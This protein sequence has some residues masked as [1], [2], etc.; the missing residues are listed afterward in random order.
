MSIF[1][2]KMNAAVAGSVH[3]LTPMTW[4]TWSSMI[5]FMM[6]YGAVKAVLGKLVFNGKATSIFKE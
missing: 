5:S 2:G 1:K 6:S 4:S 3:S